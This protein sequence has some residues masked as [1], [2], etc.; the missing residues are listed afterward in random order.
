MLPT[1]SGH[2]GG[3]VHFDGSSY[4]EVS[5]FDISRKIS[6]LTMGRGSELR[7]SISGQQQTRLL[8]G[9]VA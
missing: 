2:F 9:W 5:D 6:E 4:I 7:H 1:H 3:A 8:I